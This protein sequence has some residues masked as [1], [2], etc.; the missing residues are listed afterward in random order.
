M[1]KQ[2]KNYYR[3]Y[4]LKKSV[5]FILENNTDVFDEA[6]EIIVYY[7][8]TEIPLTGLPDYVQVFPEYLRINPKENSF[9]ELQ[10]LINWELADTVLIYRRQIPKEVTEIL[11]AK[12]QHFLDYIA[13]V[14]PKKKELDPEWE[15]IYN[16]Q[17][18]I[19]LSRKSNSVMVGALA[20]HTLVN[21]RWNMPDESNKADLIE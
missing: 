8:P 1:Q 3:N 2:S 19:F 5:K 9:K 4:Y 7:R 14:K 12:K 21:I 18:D 11:S 6:K 13:V 16:L 17:P 10:N 15:F 20:N